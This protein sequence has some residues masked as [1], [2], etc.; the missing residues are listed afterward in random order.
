MQQTS[1]KKKRDLG[2]EGLCLSRA[3][4]GCLVTLLEISNIDRKLLL[5]VMVERLEEFAL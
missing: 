5:K 2:N 4:V 1:K 3:K